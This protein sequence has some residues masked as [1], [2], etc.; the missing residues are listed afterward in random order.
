MFK[1]SIGD[2]ALRARDQGV[3]TS[4]STRGLV[5]PVVRMTPTLKSR[6]VQA[7]SW[8]LCRLQVNEVQDLWL[9]FGQR[10]RDRM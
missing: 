1:L 6:P 7:L 2:K 10:S 5:V 8:G 4:D 3:L 9:D